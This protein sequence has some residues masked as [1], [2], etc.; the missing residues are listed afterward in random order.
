MKFNLPFTEKVVRSLKLGDTVEITG[1]IFTAR[2]A[3]HQ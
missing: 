2:D 3:A 1:T